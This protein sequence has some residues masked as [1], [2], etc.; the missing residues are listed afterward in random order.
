MNQIRIAALNDLKRVTPA[1]HYMMRP[2]SIDA[3]LELTRS[4]LGDPTRLTLQEIRA[5]QA[6]HDWALCEMRFRAIS[7]TAFPVR[8]SSDPTPAPGLTFDQEREI[9]GR[10]ETSRRSALVFARTLGDAQLIEHYQTPAPAPVASES[11]SRG[12]E[13]DKAGPVDK[14]WVMKKAALIDKHAAQWATIRRDF[15]DAS[16]NGLSKAAKAHG[17]GEWFEAAALNWA[18]QRGK[19]EK[20]KEQGPANLATVWTSTKHTIEG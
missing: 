1:V 4:L 6:L 18:D 3:D 19:L 5:A 20:E 7:D 17:H 2:F 12:M 14:R 16:E 8:D 11:A 13:P 9:W 15:Q 10:R